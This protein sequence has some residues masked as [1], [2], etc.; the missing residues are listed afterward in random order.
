VFGF[1]TSWCP[2]CFHQINFSP[3]LVIPQGHQ[4]TSA[5][6]IISGG[7]HQAKAKP[8]GSGRVKPHVIHKYVLDPAEELPVVLNIEE[9]D[10]LNADMRLVR[11]HDFLG[12]RRPMSSVLTTPL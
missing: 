6:G 5:N 12:R 11:N 9:A 2:Y 3:S 8:S 10:I 7:F 1:L 4:S